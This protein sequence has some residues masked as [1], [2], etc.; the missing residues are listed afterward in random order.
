MSVS[1]SAAYISA[2]T[3]VKNAKNIADF[4]L[5]KPAATVEVYWGENVSRLL[6]GNKIPTGNYYYFKLDGDDKVYTISEYTADI[7]FKTPS[8]VRDLNVLS[9]SAGEIE[10][11]EIISPQNSFKIVKNAE[12]AIECTDYDSR[13]GWEPSM[14]Y[15]A[16]SDHLRW[17][18]AQVKYVMENELEE[19]V[20]VANNE[21]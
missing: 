12:A 8:S 5:D 20:K 15:I 21:D 4:G 2:E 10:S 6:L 13:L 9:I 17:K 7:F 19:Y 3:E 1:Y 18:I 16:D 14:E 11:F